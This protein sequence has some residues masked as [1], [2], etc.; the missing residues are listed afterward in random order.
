[1]PGFSCVLFGGQY[2]SHLRKEMI[3]ISEVLEKMQAGAVFSLKVV[4]YDRRR[5]AKSGK[6]VEY[7]EAALVW[8]DGGDDRTKKRSAER[9][10]TAL[11]RQLSGLDEHK[12][13]PNHSGWYTRNI[14][15]YQGGIPTEAVRKIHPPLII[16]FNGE[17]TCP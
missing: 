5:K 17:K 9:A 8:G 15:L 2:W 11:E 16:E 4:S 12:R 10:P 7:P 6:I 13:N 14:R 3:T 1:V